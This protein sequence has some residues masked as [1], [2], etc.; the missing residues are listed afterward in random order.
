MDHIVLFLSGHEQSLLVLLLQQHELHLVVL[1]GVV[2]P[3]LVAVLTHAVVGHIGWVDHACT[4]GCRVKVAAI[5]THL[6]HR[7]SLLT[8]WDHSSV[9]RHALV[10]VRICCLTQ[11]RGHGLVQG[12]AICF[13]RLKLMVSGLLSETLQL[14]QRHRARVD[15]ALPQEI[16][17][18]LKD[19][20]GD[21][22]R[23]THLA[24]HR[25]WRPRSTLCHLLNAATIE[26]L[27]LG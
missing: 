10:Q 15:A 20:L 27:S 11:L 13:S 16:L 21:V 9:L 14:L 3:G 19:M 23:G 6:A 24:W 5:D 22:V 25:A 1:Q 2:T 26:P 4:V 8:S 18:V 7:T 12:F 17:C